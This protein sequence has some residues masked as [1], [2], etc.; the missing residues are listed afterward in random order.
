[1]GNRFID[2]DQIWRAGGGAGAARDYGIFDMDQR[3][4]VERLLC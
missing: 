4:C 2:L 3:N 1:M